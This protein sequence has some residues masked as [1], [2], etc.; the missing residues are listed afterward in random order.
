MRFTEDL[1]EA[2]YI[3]DAHGP[4]WVSVNHVVYRSSL[5]VT[6]QRVETWRPTGFE[7]LVGEDL[8]ALQTYSPEVVLVGTGVRQ[9]FPSPELFSL[10]RDVEVSYEFMD[11]AAACRTYTI[12]M[13]E[14]RRVVAALLVNE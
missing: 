8:D 7:D 11:T 1:T 9:R 5:I 3:I 10:L 4:G 6:P 12:L 13:A 14:K 2:N